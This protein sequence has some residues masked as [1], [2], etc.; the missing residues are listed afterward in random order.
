MKM[1]A[2]SRNLFD[3]LTS[4]HRE[5]DSLFDRTFGSLSRQ[6]PGLRTQLR[7]YGPEVESYLKDNNVVYRISIPGVDPRDV[8]LSVTGNQ[9]TIK[10]ERKAPDVPENNWLIQGS[11]YGEFE[12]NLALP[13]GVE[14]ENIN[15]TF[16]N[17]IL[18]ISTPIAK[19]VLPRKVEIKQLGAADQAKSIGKGA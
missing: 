16:M 17:G 4:L 13:E 7:G 3:D 10:G 12:H 15:A 9:I 19:A 1:L 18:E 6:L 11:A 2:H 14:T 5:M 8:E